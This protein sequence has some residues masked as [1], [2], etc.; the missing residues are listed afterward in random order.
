M[1]RYTSFDE[2]M[3]DM[4]REFGPPGFNPVPFYN[5]R[6]DQLDYI[7]VDGPQYTKW[8][9]CG[10]SIYIHI[11]TE[12]II[13][14][15]IPKITRL[16]PKIQNKIEIPLEDFV[17]LSCNCYGDPQNK[18]AY[19]A[20]LSNMP[21]GVSIE[22]SKLPM[23]GK[24]LSYTMTAVYLSTFHE[25]K[26]HKEIKCEIDYNEG[27]LTIHTP[28]CYVCGN[29]IGELFENLIVE[30]RMIWNEYVYQN[31]WD[32]SCSDLEFK[33]EC[34]SLMRRGSTP[35]ESRKTTNI[36]GNT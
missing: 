8:V 18:H 12:E 15:C 13:G 19:Q 4:P 10:L 14:F 27:N 7:W 32:L 6:G 29:N 28:I 16:A 34:L 22:S 25:F 5:K 24:P 17:T 36:K 9:D 1:P 26:F 35:S 2:A 11:D 23:D 31:D 30:L 20:V 3:K 33:R 21:N